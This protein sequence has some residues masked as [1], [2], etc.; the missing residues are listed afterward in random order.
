[1]LRPDDCTGRATRPSAR[2]TA[3][4]C[5]PAGCAAR[6]R[7]LNPTVPR[8]AL[9][10]AFRKLTRPDKPSLLANNHGLHRLLVEGVTVEYQRRDGSIAGAQVR[11]LDYDD[12]GGT[13]TGWWSTSSP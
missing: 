10:E 12:P 13:T 2:T 1:M 11:V 4:S 8:P 9:D 5:S 7:G 6:W 3:R